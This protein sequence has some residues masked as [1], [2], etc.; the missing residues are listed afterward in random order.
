MNNIQETEKRMTDHAQFLVGK[1]IKRVSYLSIKESE[2]MMWNCRPIVIEFTDGS[3]MIPQ[4]DDEAN[5]GGA[6]YYQFKEEYT[7]IPTI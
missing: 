3:F 6:I 5:D 2:K 1:T 4:M 7:T